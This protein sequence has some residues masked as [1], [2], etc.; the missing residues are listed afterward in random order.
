MTKPLCLYFGVGLQGIA[1]DTVG[2]PALTMS[3]STDAKNAWT[4]HAMKKDST[5]RI[6]ACCKR[7]AAL[8]VP[9][10]HGM[11]APHT[12]YMPGA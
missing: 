9:G 1:V 4:T 2:V 7:S 6:T 3:S 8:S 11:Q 12:Q 5:P 10:S